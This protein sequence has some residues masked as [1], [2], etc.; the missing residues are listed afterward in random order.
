MATLAARRAEK[1]EDM[2]REIETTVPRNGMS[3]YCPITLNKTLT[4]IITPGASLDV[5]EEEKGVYLVKQI[6]LPQAPTQPVKGVIDFSYSF[7][8]LTVCLRL[9]L[10]PSPFPFPFHFAVQLS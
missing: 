4:V 9:P 1:F 3:K 5:I 10:C 6:V 2:D 7:G 8:P